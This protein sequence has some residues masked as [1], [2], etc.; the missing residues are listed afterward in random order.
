MAKYYYNGVLLPEIP[1][2]ILIEYPY[3]WIR[4][5]N[6]SGYYDLLM[7]ATPFYY[8]N[9]NIGPDGPMKK[10]YRTRILSAS[11]ATAWSF[12]TNDYYSYSIS[13]TRFVLWSNHDIPNGSATSATI[14]FYGSE[15]VPAYDRKY[16]LRSNST[17]YTVTDG[18][19]VP[20]PDTEI[21]ASLFRDYGVDD[22]PDGSLLAS[23]TDPE[24]LHWH[25][26]TDDLPAM[27]LTVTGT[28]PVPQVV[29]SAPMD[30]MHKSIAGIDHA[31]VTASDDVRFA[32]TFDAGVTW[33]AHDGFAWFDVSD[34]VPGMLATAMNS[35]TAEQWAEV[36]GAGS[37]MV[38]FWLPNVTAYVTSVVFHYINR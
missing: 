36:A 2:D 19:L 20:L 29:T 5:N 13:D 38:R 27:S 35:I 28:P 6:D 22:L 7:S 12:N 15:P 1:A 10:W 26:S 9:G 31:A 11:D 25:N 18:A 3:A 21:S 23:L 24:V 34:N 33:L 17:L 4:T 32:I 37:Y 30:L 8:K 16:L 14:Y